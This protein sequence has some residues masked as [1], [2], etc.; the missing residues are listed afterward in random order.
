MHFLNTQ[1]INYLTM[2]NLAISINQLKTKKD[3]HIS[4]FYLT[5]KN[6]ALLK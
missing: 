4:I 5:L 1:A 2:S 3:L 6:K